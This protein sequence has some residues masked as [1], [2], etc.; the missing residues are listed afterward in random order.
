MHHASTCGQG[1]GATVS[2]CAFNNGAGGGGLTSLSMCVINHSL[3]IIDID[4]C[5]ANLSGCSQVC[6]NTN[7]SFTCACDSGYELIDDGRTCRDINECLS[8]TDGCQQ[9]CENTDGGF[10]CEC[11]SGFQLNRDSTTCSGTRGII[12][13]RSSESTSW[14]TF[15]C[16]TTEQYHSKV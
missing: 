13:T 3:F 15:I 14:P 2:V 11:N 1:S 12:L 16:D 8:G 7:G 10:R 4:E 6:T 9:V 5:A